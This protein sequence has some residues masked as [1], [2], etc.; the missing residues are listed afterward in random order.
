MPVTSALMHRAE[1]IT[2]PDRLATVSNLSASKRVLVH[3]DRNDTIGMRTIVTGEDCAHAIQRKRFRN[4]ETDDF[5]MADRTAQNTTGQCFRCL[6]VGGVHRL[7]GD[8]FYTVDEGNGMAGRS[9]LYWRG[10]DGVPAAS[11]TDFMIVT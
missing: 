9:R 11:R 8:L 3:G 1:R 10:H 4:V 5:A 6:Q 2:G 7:S